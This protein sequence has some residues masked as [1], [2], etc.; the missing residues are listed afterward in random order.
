MNYIGRN[1]VP[2][3]PLTIEFCARIVVLS[4]CW[5]DSFSFNATGLSILGCQ[6]P[7]QWRWCGFD[8]L[9]GQRS[10][11]RL[12]DTERLIHN[13]NLRCARDLH[14]LHEDAVRSRI[15]RHAVAREPHWTE[16][17]A[18]GSEQFVQNAE[19]TYGRRRRHFSREPAS[20]HTDGERA[21]VIRETPPPYK[22]DS[23]TESTT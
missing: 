15:E 19:S 11:Y 3:Y 8:E 9:V 1:A 23:A 6:H 12:I 21:W 2:L 17:L 7:S 4:G 20:G 13:L 18:V 10:R 5:C 16:G 22:A 14:H